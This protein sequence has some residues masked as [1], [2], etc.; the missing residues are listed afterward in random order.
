MKQEGEDGE[1]RDIHKM[2]KIMKMFLLCFKKLWNAQSKDTLA[3]FLLSLKEIKVVF[4]YHF[5]CVLLGS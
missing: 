4:K 1:I 5:V 2:L 3:G